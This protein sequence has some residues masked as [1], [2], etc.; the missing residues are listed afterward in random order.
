MVKIRLAK[1]KSSGKFSIVVMDAKQKRDG[2]Y[3][4]RVGH[5]HPI[6][7]QYASEKSDKWISINIERVKYWI[8]KGAQPTEIVTRLI[9]KL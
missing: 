6:S 1:A 5:Y 2:E 7:K 8:S 9:S 3:I 4:E